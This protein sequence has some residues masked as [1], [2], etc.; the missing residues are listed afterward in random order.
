MYS[1]KLKKENTL[2]KSRIQF[3]LTMYFYFI[4]HDDGFVIWNKLYFIIQCTALRVNIIC[5]KGMINTI[6]RGLDLLKTEHSCFSKFYFISSLWH[7]LIMGIKKNVWCCK[8][9][10][11][12]QSKFCHIKNEDEN[13]RMNGC[14]AFDLPHFGNTCTG[15]ILVTS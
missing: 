12:K 10:P 8:I 3:S 15:D 13:V 9:C 11:K 4:W 7:H 14:L 1:S 5:D 2:V 6:N